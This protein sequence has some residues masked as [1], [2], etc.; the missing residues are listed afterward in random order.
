MICS[1]L[2]QRSGSTVSITRH[3]QANVDLIGM[4][5]NR[6]KR[7]TGQMMERERERESEREKEKGRIM[8]HAG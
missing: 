8:L 1:A 2:D 4:L 6:K 7:K 3:N 5:K